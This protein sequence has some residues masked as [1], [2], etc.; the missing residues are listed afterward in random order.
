MGGEGGTIR[1]GFSLSVRYP[2]FLLELTIMELTTLRFLIYKHNKP[3]LAEVEGMVYQVW[4]DGEVTL[5]KSGSL[6]NQRNLHCTIDGRP[7]KAVPADTFPTV[8]SSG[9]GFIYTDEVGALAV[10]KAILTQVA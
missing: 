8:N 3:E 6:L 5:Q 10:S 2:T 1:Y 7:D 9:Y 4:N